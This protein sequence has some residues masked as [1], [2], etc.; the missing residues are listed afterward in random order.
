MGSTN[1][2]AKLDF[3]G[4]GHTDLLWQGANGDYSI[5]YMGADGRSGLGSVYIPNPGPVWKLAILGDFSNGPATNTDLLWAPA[6]GQL[7]IWHW[8]ADGQTHSDQVLLYGSAIPLVAA[9]DFNGDG[10]DDMLAFTPP[11]ATLPNGA[12]QSFDA[13]DRKIP[14]T[15]IGG[16]APVPA[17]DRF[18]GVGDF[19]GD[20]RDDILFR[21]AAS[22]GEFLIRDVNTVMPLQTAVMQSVDAPFLGPDAGWDLVAIGDF[23]GDRHADLLWYN[24]EA[25]ATSI[26][27]MDNNAPKSMAILPDP[28]RFWTPVD[29]ADYDNDGKTDLLWRGANGAYSEWIMDG[30]TPVALG[31]TVAPLGDYWTVASA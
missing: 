8:S 23:D 2:T 25:G 17:D 28:G 31:L 18:A 7:T 20:G 22:P 1:H 6:G 24:P 9:G 3:N 12:W 26:W 16:M 21:S 15:G 27:L 4:D 19:N 29:A 30:T 5:W 11:S 14:S 13:S 10:M